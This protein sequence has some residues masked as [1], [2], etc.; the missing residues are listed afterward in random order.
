MG[1]KTCV[2]ASIFYDNVR[3]P[4]EYRGGGQQVSLYRVIRGYY[5]YVIQ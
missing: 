4:K 3:V 1:F 2:N 5:D